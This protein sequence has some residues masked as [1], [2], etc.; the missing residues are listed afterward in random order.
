MDHR[1][2]IEE[3]DAPYYYPVWKLSGYCTM[4]PSFPEEINDEIKLYQTLAE[5]CEA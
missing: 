3:D 4:L 2:A 1:V 5:C